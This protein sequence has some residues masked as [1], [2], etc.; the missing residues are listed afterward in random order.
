M[1]CAYH[2]GHEAEAEYLT[3][4]QLLVHRL[5]TRVMRGAV[6]PAA[7]REKIV[8]KGEKPPCDVHGDDNREEDG[9]VYG[10]GAMQVTVSREVCTTYTP[11]INRRES[12]LD[13]TDM[14]AWVVG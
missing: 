12:Q 9:P 10:W 11:D 13:S 1:I 3:P 7:H 4:Q 8:E 14:Q 6:L 2:A 5:W